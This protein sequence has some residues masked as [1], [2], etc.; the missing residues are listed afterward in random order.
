MKFFACL[1]DQWPVVSVYAGSINRPVEKM[2][3]H[4]TAYFAMGSLPELCRNAQQKGLNVL[5]HAEETFHG[6]FFA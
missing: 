5:M 6:D 2:N 1:A 3:F 4:A